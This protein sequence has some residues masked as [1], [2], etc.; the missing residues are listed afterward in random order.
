MSVQNSVI[1]QPLN[2]PQGIAP[3]C[4]PRRHAPRS[5]T[6]YLARRRSG[7]H[8]AWAAI[9]TLTGTVLALA[10]VILALVY[11]LLKRPVEETSAAAPAAA[12][13]SDHARPLA[14]S[15]GTAHDFKGYILALQPILV[16]PKVSGMIVKL[17][18]GEGSRVKKGDV[19]A[20]L[21]DTDYNPISSVPSGRWK[22]PAT[23][24]GGRDQSAQGDRAG[25]GGDGAVEG[26]TGRIASR[27]RA[28]SRFIF[29]A[30]GVEDGIRGRGIEVSRG[31][32]AHPFHGL[33]PGSDAGLLCRRSPPPIASWKRPRPIW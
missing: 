15:G 29:Q 10:S 7:A 2:E 3:A 31:R 28:D 20:E 9:G 23:A 22:P 24:C 1:D 27:I 21:E 6:A 33:C 25:R 16:S 30:G 19:L 17:H 13:A 18:I 5:L 14:V 32:A 8:L 4:L 11:L 26:R 12:A